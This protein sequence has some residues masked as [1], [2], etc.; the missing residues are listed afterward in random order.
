MMIIFLVVAVVVVVLIV[1]L[2]GGSGHSGTPHAPPGKTP[3][4]ILK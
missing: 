3:L 1:R 2:L 4:D